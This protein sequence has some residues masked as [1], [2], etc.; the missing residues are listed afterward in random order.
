MKN[1]DIRWQQRFNN[2][3][4]ALVRLTS[5]I[6]LS[7]E[8]DL[9]DLEQQGLIQGFEFTFDIA[10]KTIKDFVIEKGYQGDIERPIPIID[11]AGKRGIINEKSWRLMYQSR[12]KTSHAYDEEVA[13]EVAEKIIAIYHDLFIQLETRLEVERLT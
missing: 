11:E 3:K 10:W 2:F 1:K 8:R 12:N 9:S 5:A 7:R 4:K 6:E 13:D